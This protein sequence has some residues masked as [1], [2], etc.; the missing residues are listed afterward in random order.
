MPTLRTGTGLVVYRVNP[1]LGYNEEMV[2]FGRVFGV[3]GVGV[4]EEK[5]D[6]TIVVESFCPLSVYFSVI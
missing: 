3:K 2:D 4:G 6:S 1:K 5:K